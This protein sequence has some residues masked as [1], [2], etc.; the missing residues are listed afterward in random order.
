MATITVVMPT[1][2]R[3]EILIEALKH[4]ACGS[5]Q[6]DEVIVVDDGSE[7]PVP[8]HI[9]PADYPFPMKIIRHPVGRGAPVARNAGICAATSEIVAL[10]DDDVLVD[11]NCIRYHKRIHEENPD[12]LYGIQGRIYFDPDLPRTPLMHYLEEYGSYVG[13][14]KIPDRQ[15]ADAGVITSNISLKRSIIE[16]EYLF[17]EHFP[18]NRN[19]DTEFGLRLM[20]KGC[21]THFHIAPTARH[22]SS[23]SL[24][25]YFKTVRQGG[26][27]KAHWSSKSPDESKNC[28]L[29]GV[30]ASRKANEEGFEEVF[31]GYMQRFSPDFASTRDISEFFPADLDE[32]YTFLKITTGW[33]QDIA[34]VDGWLDQVDGF[35]AMLKEIVLGLTATNVEERLDC[36]RRA[37]AINPVFLPMVILL[38]D[39]LKATGNLDEARKVLLPS[40][41]SIWVLLRLGEIEFQKGEYRLSLEHFMEVYRRTGHGKRVQWEQRSIM[42][43]TLLKLVDKTRQ[44]GQWAVDLWKSLSQQDIVNQRA[45]FEGLKKKL[46]GRSEAEKHAELEERF[47]LFSQL[48]VLQRQLRDLG[49]DAHYNCGEIRKDAN[50]RIRRMGRGIVDRIKKFQT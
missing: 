16:P 12:P 27:S 37:R 21:L 8:D 15:V 39:E 3:L 22:R 46:G 20:E 28:L 10:I 40:S 50:D 26:F 2:N 35:D 19:E 23:I 14:C 6:P 17:D 25:T 34:I 1:H 44:D 32:F 41:S 48:G 38:A 7:Q 45:L 43:D 24:E 11:Y 30:A 33:I 29:L 4:L 9:D 13:T 5:V 36:F 31:A 42:S 49:K 47:A 18:F